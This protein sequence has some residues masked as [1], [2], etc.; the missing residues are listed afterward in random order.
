M[1]DYC[2]RCG[3]PHPGVPCKRDEAERLKGGD[4]QDWVDLIHDHVGGE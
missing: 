1:S 2:M 4:S 3:I